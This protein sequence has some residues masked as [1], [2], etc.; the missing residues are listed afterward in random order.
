MLIKANIGEVTS[1]RI[2]SGETNM[3]VETAAKIATLLG[4]EI[5]ELIEIK[6]F[7]KK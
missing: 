2:W 6:T 5:G 3:R 1:R 7:P 4:V